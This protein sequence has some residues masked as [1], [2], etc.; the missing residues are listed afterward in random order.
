MAMTLQTQR[1]E[2]APNPT[3]S[4]IILHGLGADGSDFISF[5]RE[6]K[7]TSV[8]PVRFVFPNAPHI[9]VTING[10]HVMPAWYDIN[11][12]N[13]LHREDEAGLR[14]SQSQI[15]ALVDEE[16]ASGI[17]PA[18]TVLAGFSQGCAMALMVGL[19]Y[20]HRLAGIVGMSGYLPLAATTALERH[21]ANHHAHIFM[22]HGSHDN[23]V[24]LDR[25]QASHAVLAAQGDVVQ[26]HTYPM[27][28]SVCAQ[29]VS[30]LN[31]WLLK[32]L[33]R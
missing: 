5:V 17:A 11:N 19:R 16:R 28:H 8:G 32:V 3:A 1:V 25:A 29:E 24:P 2:T 13:L 12:A 20:P 33:A 22:A 4:I 7:L 21:P 6:L 18:R 23:V 15:A 10:G 30:D 9:P 14:L 27:A 26:W 31:A